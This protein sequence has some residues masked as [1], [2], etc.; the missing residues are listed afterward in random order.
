MEQAIFISKIDKLKCVSQVY[1]R[2]Y[3]GNEFCQRLMPGVQEVRQAFDFV[4]ERNMHLSFVTPYVTNQGIG[5]LKPVLEE[6]FVKMSGIEI[7]VNDW[8]LLRFLRKEYAYP[9]LVLGRLLTKQKRGPRILNLKDMLSDD[10]FTHFQESN[11][12]VPVLSDFL[13]DWGIKRVELD[14]LLQGLAREN[15]QIKGSLYFPFAYVTTTRFC[16]TAS[17]EKET[18]FLR[19]IRPCDKQCRKYGFVLRHK[20]MPVELFL[21][22]NTQFFSNDSLPGGL[23]KLNIDRLVF[24]PEVPI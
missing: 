3:F 22:G 2:L 7:V 18:R 20:N 23:D 21:K 4:L 10:A 12:D 24:Q 13:F 19:S 8:G 17:C 11:I 1:T 5:A 6:I 9:N 15:P 14:N 16:P